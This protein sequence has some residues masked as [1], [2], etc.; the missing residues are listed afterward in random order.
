VK[1]R[2]LGHVVLYVRDLET[3]L[4][5]WRDLLGFEQKGDILG[6]KAAMLT[7]GRIHHEVL[8]IEV[9]DAPGPLRGHRLGLYHIG[10]CVGDSDDE[11]RQ[12]REELLAAG[13]AI[14]GTADHVITHSLYV[15]DPDGNEVEL[16]VDV[17]DYDWEHDLEWIE[18]PVRPL[19]L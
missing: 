10:V 12:V 5:F 8:L 15:E 1:A 6:G 2:F 7:S 18:D 19:N 13:V 3:S 14:S 17:P 9:G 16:Y 4:T 11:L